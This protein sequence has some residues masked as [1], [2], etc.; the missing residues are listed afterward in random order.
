MGR[1]IEVYLAAGDM[2]GFLQVLDPEAGRVARTRARPKGC[3]AAKVRCL[4]CGTVKLVA[5]VNLTRR[6]YPT[7]SCGCWRR[8][9]AGFAGRT[10]D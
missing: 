8:T 4:R 10:S 9:G 2:F 7:V 3:R 5:I 1:R 6:D